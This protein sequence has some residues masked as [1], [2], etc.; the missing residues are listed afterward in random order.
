MFAS[1]NDYEEYKRVSDILKENISLVGLLDAAKNT[2]QDNDA[3]WIYPFYVEMCI[4][5]RPKISSVI[6][7]DC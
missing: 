1:I 3:A 7:P 6:Q 2:C 4:R 5:D